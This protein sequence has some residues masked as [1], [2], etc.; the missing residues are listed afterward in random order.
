VDRIDT[1]F[2][3]GM[4]VM[5]SILCT[6]EV[7]LT[8]GRGI[9]VPVLKDPTE[10]ANKAQLDAAVPRLFRYLKN[11]KRDSAMRFAC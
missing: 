4:Q 3:L 8:F 5:L 7:R 6:L 11:I 9:G 10:E 2:S 1:I